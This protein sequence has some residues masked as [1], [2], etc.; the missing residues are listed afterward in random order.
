MN[1]VYSKN[2]RTMLLHTNTCIL[3]QV[4]LAQNKMMSYVQGMKKQHE[5]LKAIFKGLYVCILDLRNPMFG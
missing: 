3:I 1:L 4:V 5:D 2:I